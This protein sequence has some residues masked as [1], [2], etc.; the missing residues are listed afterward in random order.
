MHGSQ[1]VVLPHFQYIIVERHTWRYEFGYATPHNA[2]GHGGVFE[3]VADGYA[4]ARP[5]KFGQIGVER[6]V[7]K[8]CQLFLRPAIVA[9]REDNA[10][11]TTGP[12][13]IFAEGL[14]KIAHPKQQ[15]RTRIFGLD[16]V[17]LTIERR[18]FDGSGFF[19]GRRSGHAG[20]G[21]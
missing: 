16:L 5:H 21:S 10:Q 1:I 6:M 18:F 19:N 9:A 12:D 13:G 3:L 4:L 20:F 14:V 11:N 8:T 15:Q 17:V 7:R 2:F